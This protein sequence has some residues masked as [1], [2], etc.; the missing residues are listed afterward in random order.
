MCTIFRPE[1][2]GEEG[3]LHPVIIWGNGTFG[4]PPVYQG[5]LSHWASH[6]FVVAAANTANAGSGQEMLAC[7]DYLEA[8]HGTPGSVYEG[9]LDLTRVGASGHSQGGGGAI[10]AGMDV[11]VTTTAPVQPFTAQ[12]FGGYDQV[13]QG[14]QT[15]P[16]LLLSGGADFTAPIEPHQ[17]RVW[18]TANV[19]VVWAIRAGAGH[20]IGTIGEMNSF[21]AETTA[22][23][24]YQL[25]CE[26][27][28]S[29]L[30]LEPC[31]L[32]ESPDWEIQSQGF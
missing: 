13:A 23:W 20:S 11:R 29:A 15:G 22:W 2:L 19:P 26:T 28:A 8:E 16:M 10:M 25:M 6:G 21:R 24:R 4:S 14:L 12:G 31:S 17:Q 30:F 9:M 1:V 5:A 7:L 18:D 27:G 32:C 3:R